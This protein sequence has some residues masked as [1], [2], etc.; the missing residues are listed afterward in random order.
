MTTETA[1]Q[2]L[3]ILLAFGGLCFGIYERFER[4]KIE[5]VL[6]TITKTFPGDIAKIYESCRWGWTNVRDAHKEALK[7]PESEEKHKVLTFV[8]NAIG[9]T[10]ASERMCTNLFNQI[11]GFQEAQFGTRDIAHP[12][13]RTLALF[14][15]EM[16]KTMA[17]QNIK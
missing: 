9:D 4:R 10:A 1:L 8:S 15:A 16:E 12:H 11:L 6:K 2:S 7:V 13:Q 17:N 5:R 3:E 14:Q